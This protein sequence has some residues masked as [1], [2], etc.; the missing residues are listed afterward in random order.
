MRARRRKRKRRRDLSWMFKSQVSMRTS[1]SVPNSR[2][3][4]P[5]CPTNPLQSTLVPQDPLAM[6]KFAPTITTT[7]TTTTTI[8]DHKITRDRWT[9][10]KPRPECSKLGRAR[11]AV[12]ADLEV[13]VQVAVVGHSPEGTRLG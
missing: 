2:L 10:T 4:W 3:L 12:G 11:A 13:V 6:L 8:K 1:A 5:S 9:Q 7:L